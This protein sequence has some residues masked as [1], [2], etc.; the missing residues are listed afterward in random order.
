MRM[1][2]AA[3]A[4]CRVPL[5]YCGAHTGRWS[6]GEKINLQN[7]GSRGHELISAVRHM[8]VAPMARCSS[9]WTPRRSKL[10]CSRGSP[11]SGTC[12]EVREGRGNLLRLREQGARLPRPQAQEKGRPRLHRGDRKRHDVGT[13]LD[14]QGR[15]ARLRLRHGHR[16][17]LRVRG[18]AIDIETAEKIKVVYRR[19]PPAIVSS[20]GTSRRRSSTRPSTSGRARCLVACGSTRTDDCDVMITLPN[21]RELKYH[22]VKLVPT[23]AATRSK[24]G[25]APS[26][27]G[28]TFGAGT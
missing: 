14:R 12:G 4:G 28:N 25:T 11:A 17:H 27:T 18:R 3:A 20:G 8:L 24:C 19:E 10:A 21:G 7:L 5:K 13:Q 6:G 15:R 1:A 23:I 22:R 9:S 2:R 26:T 16:P